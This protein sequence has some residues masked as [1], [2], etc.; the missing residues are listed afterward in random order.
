MKMLKGFP[1]R[2]LYAITDAEFKG[3]ALTA[4]VERAI[5]GGARVIQYRD[6]SD[7][8]AQRLAESEAILSVCQHHRI[9]LL[10]NDDI[11][12]ASHIGAHGVHIGREDTTLAKA[13]ERLGGHAIIGVSCYNR[14]EL[15]QQ[16]VEAGADYVA[17]GRFFKSSSKPEAVQADPELLHRARAELSCPV[18]A[19]GGITP[20]NG[21]R[22]I[23]A[24]ADMLA[25][26]RGVFAADDPTLAAK[27]IQN[28]FDPD[29]E[30]NS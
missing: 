21:A 16:A 14:F 26:I 18:V 27:S 10:I 23:R 1:F 24:G 5:Q 22:L 20:D 3:E 15:A 12:L 6:K 25:V 19:I 11:E 7:D 2:G 4:Q 28:L 29:V 30:K 13:R 8:L 17:F 9:P